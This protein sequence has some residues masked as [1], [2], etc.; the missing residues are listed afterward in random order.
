MSPSLKKSLA[1]YSGLLT[2]TS[3]RICG[4]SFCNPAFLRSP[5]SLLP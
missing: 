4:N 3:I 5:L 2:G 1:F